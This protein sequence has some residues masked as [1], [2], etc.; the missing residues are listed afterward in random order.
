M[1]LTG[2]L[3]SVA[4]VGSAAAPAHA[5]T[6]PFPLF[7]PVP[8]NATVNAGGPHPNDGDVP[9]TRNSVDV[10]YADGSKMG[11]YAA[12][13]GTVH[14]H[15]S[16]DGK[17]PKC[18]ASITDA[19]GWQTQYWHLTQALASVDNHQVQAGTQLGMD[20]WP[21]K[22]TCGIGDATHLHFS[23]WHN[24]SAVA[25]DGTSIG[26]YTVHQSGNN[27]CG[28]WTL[29]SNPA[30]IVADARTACRMVPKLVNNVTNPQQTS[31][32]DVET[33]PGSNAGYTLTSDGNL[34]PFGGA[35]SATP[36]KT[37]TWPI[38]RS[39]VLL[40][41]GTGG[42]VLDGWGGVHPFRIGTNP[43]PP[44]ATPSSYWQGWD[45]ARDLLIRSDATGGYV[46]DGYGGLH[47]FTV[48]GHSAPPAPHGSAYWSGSDIA[49]RFALNQNGTAG[50]VLDGFG[51]LHPFSTGDSAMP[52]SV[53]A[54]TWP[55]WDIARDV[56][57]GITGS[58]GYT[59]DGYGG[60]H[61]FYAAGTPS[62]PAMTSPDYASGQDTARALVM[63]QGT[64]S[65]VR[66]GGISGVYVTTDRLA[67]HNFQTV[68]A[69]RSIAFLPGS[70]TAGYKL[71]GNGV[72]TA[73]GGAPAATPSAT[74]TW[75]IAR[76]L[77]ILPSGTGGYVLD[78]WG[79]FHPF[80]IG[81]NAAPPAATG[82]PSWPGWDIAR[83]F[84]FTAAGKGGYVLDGYGGL[85][86]FAIGSNAQPPTITG[87]AY[88]NGNDIARSIVLNRS[89]TGGYVLEG[90]GGLHPFALGSNPMQ[91]AAVGAAYFPGWDIARDVVLNT[92]GPGGY[93]LDGYGALHPFAVGSNPM[94]PPVST[95]YYPPWDVVTGLAMSV[96]GTVE[97]ID[98][99]GGVHTAP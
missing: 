91:P 45:I 96:G 93:V 17:W 70:N 67:P 3:A 23:L 81:S 31:S 66:P 99:Q 33:L 9:G 29:D 46:L 30:T 24:G 94:A 7:L 82:G 16:S 27:Y 43:M 65:G 60:V 40:A 52:P 11:V 13:A 78:G 28:Y 72:I 50:Y 51:G 68:A 19:N 41:D 14:F 87:T 75:D 63:V 97:T 57:I 92:T 73:I 61:P 35:A 77:R 59:L 34:H 21:G 74:W 22:N 32:A 55:G 5:A 2:L 38:A 12:M 36:S 1:S 56:A 49:H 69:V 58:S 71:R 80:S 20:G 48:A 88:W 37:W 4:I 89:G 25:I 15:D 90:F 47:T 8:V 85:H 18:W 98:S 53:S 62:P 83:S 10:G 76:E 44:N 84:I 42:Y 95:A 6:L 86:P 26:G 64:G 54:T 79:G 39:F